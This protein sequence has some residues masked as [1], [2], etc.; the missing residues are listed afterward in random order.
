MKTGL[1]RIAIGFAIAAALLGACSDRAIAPSPRGIAPSSARAAMLP[2]PSVRFSEIHYDN[3]GTDANER[4]EVSFPTGTDLTGWSIVLYNGANGQS[5]DTR[6]LTGVAATS[7]GASSSRSVAVV[8]YAVNGIQN[9]DPDGMALVSPTG[10]VEFLSYEGTFVAANGPASGMTSVDIGAREAGTEPTTNSLSRNA[11][12]VW[13]SGPS[14][15]GTPPCSDDGGVAGPVTTVTVAPTPATITVGTTQQFTATA[16]DA[17]G[18]PVSASFTWSSSDPAVATVST[19]GLATGVTAGSTTITAMASGVDGTASLTVNAAHPVPADVRIVEIHYDNVGTDVGEAIEIEGPA[20]T[21]LAGWSLVLYNGNGGASYNTQNLSGTIPATCGARGVVVVNYGS[22]IQNGSPDGVALVSPSGVVEFLS[23]EGTFVATNGPANGMTST[24]IGV[25]ENPD[26]SVPA[27]QSLQRASN[28]TWSGPSTSSFGACNAAAPPSAAPIVINEL[29]TDPSKA[30]GGAS[31]GEWFEV[32]NIGTTPI[33][34]QG[35]TIVS[36]GQPDH[37]IATSLVVQPGGH[38]VLGRSNDVT[39]NGGVTVDYSY[40]TGSTSTTI[41]LDNTDILILRDGAGATVDSVR[42]QTASSM[43]SG[44]TRALK[45][46]TTNNANVDGSNWGYSTTTFGDG[47]YGTPRAANAPVSDTPP[48]VANTIT[49]SGRLPSDPFLPV[50]YEDQLFATLRQGGASGPTIPTT[51]T[52]TAETPHIATIDANGVMHGVASGMA[53]FR[54]TAADG[55]TGT[56]TLPIDVATLGNTALYA[57]NTEFGT[58]KDADPSDDFIIVRS[59]LTSSYNKNRSTP[60]WVAYNLDPTHFGSNVD[61]CDCFTMDPL[62]PSDYLRINT[63]DYTGGGAF[64]GYGIDRGHLARSFDR[65]SGTLDNA[66]TYLFSNI[67]P[68]AADM[69]QGPWAA[70]ENALGDMARNQNKEVYIIAGVAGNKGTVK[71]ENKIVI[72]TSTWKV[73]V[74]VGHDKGLADVTSLADLEVIAVN[75]PNE[76]GIRNVAWQTYQTTVSAIETSTGYDLL[77]LLPEAIE[78]KVEVRNCL[79]QATLVPTNGSATVKAGVPLSLKTTATD[80]D[81]ADG[82]W[83]LVYDFGDG[84]TFTSTLFA[85]PTPTTPTSRSKTWTTPGVYTVTTT[86]TDKKGGSSS[87]SLQITVT[88]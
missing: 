75:M 18:N 73:A 82:P 72:P 12:D 34:M 52:W 61:R 86:L 19:T 9:G 47:D 16:T 40:F 50:G 60:N 56:T 65:T 51:F 36:S 71:G 24:D 80:A 44:V 46:A 23:Y 32:T 15:F 2:M 5:Y 29:M 49:F 7:C 10:V 79:P 1:S 31:F 17:S 37:V 27:G 58:P 14:S 54:A 69:N 35:W 48:V 28:G 45:D 26:N 83:K 68:Q 66:L 70:L 20:G 57:N 33:D 11:S 67:V 55:S 21:S 87:V 42:W 64:A 59:Q 63:N 81:G 85:L 25:S 77:D 62:L 38:A 76:P 41:F 4:I 88:P 84:T 30:T 43:V 74:I 3:A 6:S 39:R 78:C 8:A 53:T 13:T 22:V